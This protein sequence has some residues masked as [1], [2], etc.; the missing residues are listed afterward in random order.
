MA[1]FSTTVV[2]SRQNPVDWR[3]LLQE[4]PTTV[5]IS[6]GLVLSYEAMIIQVSSDFLAHYW[7][8]VVMENSTFYTTFDQ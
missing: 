7:A 1:K 2:L 4:F 5:Q 3:S 8:P 6:F